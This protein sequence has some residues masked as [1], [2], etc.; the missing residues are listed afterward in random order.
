MKKSESKGF[1][2][3][4]YFFDT[5]KTCY[6]RKVWRPKTLAATLENWLW[7]KC[8]IDKQDYYMNTKAESY[9][10]K[11]DKNNPVEDFTFQAFS[12]NK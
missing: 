6:Y 11:F 1:F 2:C 9:Y 10:K 8:Y 4:V 3:V 5:K 12:K 7:L